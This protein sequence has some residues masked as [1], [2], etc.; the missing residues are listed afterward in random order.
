MAITPRTVLTNPGTA[1]IAAASLFALTAAGM[2]MFTTCPN[3][4]YNRAPCPTLDIA[5][6]V[7]NPCDGALDQMPMQRAQWSE[8][9]WFMYANCFAQ[10]ED[11]ERVI[12]EASAGIEYYPT[13]EALF[14]LKGYHLIQLDRHTEAVETLK[15]GLRRIGQPQQ[16][17]L[18]NNLAWAGLWVPR[19]LDLYQARALYKNALNKGQNVCEVIHTGLWVEYAVAEQSQGIE[20]A[21][22]LRT[23]S[24]LR[25]RYA[26]CQGRY[27]DGDRD[28]LLEVLSALIAFKDVDRELNKDARTA[29]VTEDCASKRLASDVAR[30]VHES[31]RG[32]SVDEV[33]RDAV[34]LA[35]AHHTCVEMVEQIVSTRH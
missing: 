5:E 15:L 23:F 32:V 10:L 3:R 25:E 26:P 17:T 6:E 30:K 35:T 24:D 18:E 11:S 34:P 20:R 7:M 13:S 9:N 12:T 19:E 31:Y 28:Q 27:D 14:N 21:R 16:G 33:C 8:Y 1:A 2:A 4:A 29:H 22:A